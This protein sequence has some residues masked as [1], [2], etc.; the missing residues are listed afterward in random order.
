[1]LKKSFLIYLVGLFILVAV[2]VLIFIYAIKKS[3][4]NTDKDGFIH[5]QVFSY[6]LD[7]DWEWNLKRQNGLTDCVDAGESLKIKCNILGGEIKSLESGNSGFYSN[8]DY[9]CWSKGEYSDSGKICTR[10][11]DCQGTCQ[12]PSSDLVQ[13][14]K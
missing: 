4:F 6:N 5:K 1:M 14:N 10:D 12:E 8:M 7:G 3:Q 9:G 13:P 2:G 11:S